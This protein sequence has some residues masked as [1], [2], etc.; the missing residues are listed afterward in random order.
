MFF[1]DRTLFDLTYSEIFARYKRRLLITLFILILPLLL[2][3]LL[4]RP[5]VPSFQIFI[6]ILLVFALFLCL[7]FTPLMAD[8]LIYLIVCAFG[9]FIRKLPKPVALTVGSET[10]NLL[11]FVLKKRRRIALE[12]LRLAF[13]TEKSDEERKAICRENFRHLGKTAI[14]FFRF[15]LL[16][17][18][19]IWKEVTVEGGE[20]L[21]QAFARG[22]GVIVFLPHFGN[23]E[24]LAL[25]YGALIPDRAKAIAFPVKNKHLNTLV[26][27]YREHL[28]LRLITRKDAVKETL[29]AL[30][31]NFA[32]G[33]F[34]DQ[35]AGREGVFVDFF[36]KLASAVRGPVT[37]ALKTDAPIL[38][39]MDVR[40][41]DN[42]HR[43]LISPPVNL[44]ISGNFEQDVQIN[45]ER[46]LK[47]LEGH[48]RQHPDQWLWLHKRWKTQ[49]D[50][51]WQ[52]KH[53][54]RMSK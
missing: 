49:P 35:N 40:Q 43:V 13:G 41:P 19:N 7:A 25:V 20:N 45:T 8:W 37:L 52:M 4:S 29:R 36:G 12:N 44:E 14:E 32:V 38:F 2:F 10:G 11:Y 5:H 1:D 39:S 28:S 26:S 42:R 30:K 18:D 31:D 54:K 48:I 3:G 23:W 6:V 50:A 47:I 33:F 21:T 34:A 53:H 27:K 16:T 17:F 46:L 51:K 15:P 9:W 24:L 22:K